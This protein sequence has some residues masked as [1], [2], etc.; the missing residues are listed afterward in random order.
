MVG[1]CIF[2]IIIRKAQGIIKYCI[3]FA[4]I[5]TNMSS[6]KT[7]DNPLNLKFMTKEEEM[8]YLISTKK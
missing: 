5:K 3:L 6:I 2:G 8:K 7:K 4:V 1:N